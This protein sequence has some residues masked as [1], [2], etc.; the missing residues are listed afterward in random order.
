MTGRPAVPNNSIRQYSNWNIPL[1]SGRGEHPTFT[2]VVGSTL[3]L[4]SVGPSCRSKA[5]SA[6]SPVGSAGSSNWSWFSSSPV[7]SSYKVTANVLP[8]S[9]FHDVPPAVIPTDEQHSEPNSGT[10]Y[11]FTLKA[12]TLTNPK[13]CSGNV[14][15][16]PPA[17]DRVMRSAQAGA[18]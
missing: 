12:F 11:H 18:I 2:L 4:R 1:P 8:P 13:A 10:L 16:N 9:P 7:P 5:G 3:N 14:F 15:K 17:R 6:L